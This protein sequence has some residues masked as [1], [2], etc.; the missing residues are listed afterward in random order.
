MTFGRLIDRAGRGRFVHYHLGS[1]TRIFG[2]EPLLRDMRIRRDTRGFPGRSALAAG[3]VVIAVLAGGCSALSGN[4][5]STTSPTGPNI[6]VSDSH[7]GAT[8]VR[9]NRNATPLRVLSISPASGSRGVEFTSAITVRFSEP[10]ASNAAMP[11]LSPLPPGTW[12]IKAANVLV[13]HPR[14]NY[15]PFVTEHLTLP[16]GIHGLLGENGGILRDSMNA[17]FTVAGS[18]ELRL[19][20]LLAELGYLPLTFTPGSAAQESDIPLTSDITAGAPDHSTTTTRPKGSTTTSP[21]TTTTTRPVTTTRP[22]PTTTTSSTTTTTAP[23]PPSTVSGP[24]PR[25]TMV[26]EPSIAS[27]IPLTPLSGH[28]AWRFGDIPPTLAALWTAGHPNAITTAAIMQFEAAHGLTTDGSAGPEVWQALLRAVARRQMNKAPYAYV[29][30]T[31]SLP[32]TVNLWVDGKVIFQTPCNTGIAAAP[33]AVGTWPV[34]VRYVTTTM[35]GK[36]PG[37]SVYHDPGIPWVSYF[38]GSDALHGFLRYSYGF[39]QS[40]GCVEMPY[41]AAGTVYPWTPIGTLVT[42]E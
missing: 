12:S 41:Q 24:A 7:T 16:G 5:S 17:N 32:E 31:T 33:T 22:K 23:A 8:P 27:D 11:L 19:Q 4:S 39:P 38:H 13:F 42:I 35:S 37:G 40:L 3:L 29:Y 6:G 30:V 20:Q 14:G 18:S 36:N 25:A 21:T 2:G 9:P 15:A 1:Q 34:Y 10:L 26:E 28:F